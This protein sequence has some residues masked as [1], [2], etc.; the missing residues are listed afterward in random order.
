MI[1][2][3]HLAAAYLGYLV[4]RGSI[5]DSNETGAKFMCMLRFVLRQP[6]NSTKEMF[7][8]SHIYYT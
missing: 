1:H 2:F 7:L 8:L 6:T 5:R 4:I 3:L